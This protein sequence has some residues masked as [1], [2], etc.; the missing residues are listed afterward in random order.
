MKVLKH[1]MNTYSRSSLTNIAYLNGVGA[2][3][4]VYTKGIIK[5]NTKL[6][7]LVYHNYPKTNSSIE[8][9]SWL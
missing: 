2:S 6:D 3:I 7:I 8:N 9:K 4:N 1:K 5:D